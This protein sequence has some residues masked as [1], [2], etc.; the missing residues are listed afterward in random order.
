MSDISQD[1][2]LFTAGGSVTGIGT[3]EVRTFLLKNPS[4]SGVRATI[5]Q[6]G[7]SNLHT[8]SSFIQYRFYVNPTIT[9]DGTALTENTLDIG[10]GKTAGCQA[11]LSPTISA[12]GTQ[13]MQ[14]IVPS[15]I[16]G[17]SLFV[18]FPPGFQLR[19][20]N[21]LLIT[22]TADGASRIASHGIFW[23]ED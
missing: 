19:E 9:S 20:N 8:V 14:V 11:F 6:V 5:K 21:N 15:G 3:T 16:T 1:D 13:I 10:S 23:E 12:N 22:A 4:G 18:Y 17:G 2:K 7:V